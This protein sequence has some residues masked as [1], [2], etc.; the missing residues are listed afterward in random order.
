MIAHVMNENQNT[1][2][3]RRRGPRAVIF[4]SLSVFLAT[5]TL[6]GWQVQSGHDPAL[7]GPIAALVSNTSSPGAAQTKTSG[8]SGKATTNHAGK[9][10]GAS[11]VRTSSSGGGGRHHDHEND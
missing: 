5:L 6:L 10:H 11:P 1:A 7:N 3:R 8:H 9:R 4:G 2:K